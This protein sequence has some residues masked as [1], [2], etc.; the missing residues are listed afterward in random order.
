[1]GG[2][3]FV[4]QPGLATEIGADGTARDAKDAPALGERL[5][6]VRLSKT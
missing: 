6:S 4:Q 5:L 2:P 3:P 1:V